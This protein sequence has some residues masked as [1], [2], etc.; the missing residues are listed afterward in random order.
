MFKSKS[1]GPM[2]KPDMEA[3][4]D[5]GE[6]KEMKTMA[7]KKKKKIRNLDDLKMVAKSFEGKK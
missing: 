1:V 5:A 4:M 2:M 7:G 3:K 6:S